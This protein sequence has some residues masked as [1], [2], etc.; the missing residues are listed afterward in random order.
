VHVTLEGRFGRLAQ[1]PR[2]DTTL[3]AVTR[4]GGALWA[5]LF[6]G[7]YADPQDFEAHVVTIAASLH[8]PVYWAVADR[9]DDAVGWLSL[10]RI[11]TRH[12]VIKF[13]SILYTPAMQRTALFPG[14]VLLARHVFDDLGYRRYE[15]KCNDLNAPSKRSAVRFGFT[16]EG[17][18]RQHMIVKGRN[19]DTAWFAML[20]HEWPAKK[21]AYERWL[22]PGNFDA[23][24]RQRTR[25]GA[26][27]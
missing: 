18:F 7:P 22:A 11:D 14:A 10:M 1:S 23:D 3:R 19:R 12:R 16:Y 27:N 15:W 5:Y 6:T 2:R 13:G 25:L 9:N 17:L 8:D 26:V 20:D 4:R 24:G 21:V